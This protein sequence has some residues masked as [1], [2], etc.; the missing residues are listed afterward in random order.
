MVASVVP[1]RI[2]DAAFLTLGRNR[3]AWFGKTETCQLPSP[4]RAH[5]FLDNALIAQLGNGGVGAVL[6]NGE[7]GAR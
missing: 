1:R 6:P 5:R 3:Y 7:K 4:E 2:R